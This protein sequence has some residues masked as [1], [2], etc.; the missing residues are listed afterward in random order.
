MSARV[1]G[2]ADRWA[3]VE[4]DLA[5]LR[6]NAKAFRA[7][8]RPG[9]KMMAVIKADA[10]GHGAVA[11]AKTLRSAGADQFAVATVAEGVE[12]RKAGFDAP[13]LILSQPPVDCV[14]TLVEYDLMPSV[15]E[16]DFALALGEAAA[17]EGKVA[18]Y[19]LA[20]DTGMTRIGVRRGDVLEVAE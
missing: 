14:G 5:A 15:Y 8:I 19:H 20:L 10:Y 2:P 3:W 6:R 11:C 9:T 12:L 17:A 13:I 7:Q 18:K 1:N 4:V 16:V